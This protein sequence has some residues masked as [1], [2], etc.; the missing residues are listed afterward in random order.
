MVRGRRGNK[1]RGAGGRGV[2]P[3]RVSMLEGSNPQGDEH[4][5]E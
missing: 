2:P 3:P 4:T 5:T 1:R